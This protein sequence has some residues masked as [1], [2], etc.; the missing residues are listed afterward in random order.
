MKA[1]DLIN[2][3][4]SDIGTSAVDNVSQWIIEALS[5]IFMTEFPWNRKE[6]R[7]LTLASE[8]MLGTSGTATFQWTE[9]DSFILCSETVSQYVDFTGRKVM[10]G[11]E[12]YT[13]IDVGLTSAQRIYVDREI[14]G[15][16]TDQQPYFYRDMYSVKSAVIHTV[17]IDKFKIVCL[18]EDSIDRSF[19]TN[20]YW[21]TSDWVASYVDENNFRIAAPAYPPVI[22]STTGTAFDDGDYYYAYTRYDVE[23]GHESPLGPL[24][25]YTSSGGNFPVV[26]YGNTGNLSEYSTY[27]MRL[28]RSQ[29]NPVSAVMPMFLIDTSAV[30]SSNPI[31]FT[32]NNTGTL[33]NKQQYYNG[34]RTCIRLN[35]PPSTTRKSLLIK[36]NDDYGYRLWEDEDI[37]VGNNN[38]VLEL[39]RLYCRAMSLIAKNDTAGTRSAVAHFRQQINYHVSQSRSAGSSDRNNLNHNPMYPGKGYSDG[40]DISILL[41]LTGPFDFEE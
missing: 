27:R 36:H 21:D 35:P 10:L 31:S 18:N 22:E 30:S 33:R 38:I 40:R 3:I 24:L 14:V 26:K 39:V 11:D 12:S 37:D 9:G 4:M 2:T 13:I 15:S 25:K 20:R 23:S 7:F 28:W 5:I 29:K 19:V 17:E 32:D 41:G 16:A 1:S 34:K 6:T 8:Q